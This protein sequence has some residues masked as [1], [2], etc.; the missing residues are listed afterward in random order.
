MLCNEEDCFA[1]RVVTGTAYD[2]EL[3][4]E[5]EPLIGDTPPT[6]PRAALDVPLPLQR[7]QTEHQSSLAADARQ[8]VIQ[9]ML[10]SKLWYRQLHNALSYVLAIPH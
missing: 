10:L 8:G 7:S 4:L 1:T 9:M 3:C 2:P 5:Q 6:P